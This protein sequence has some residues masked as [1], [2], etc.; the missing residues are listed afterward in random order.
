[1]SGS[2]QGEENVSDTDSKN[3]RVL[4]AQMRHI[5]EKV[6]NHAAL[7]TSLGVAAAKVRGG[8]TGFTESEKER[9]EEELGKAES[10]ARNLYDSALLSSEIEYAQRLL[11][12]AAAYV[13]EKKE[14]A[15]VAVKRGQKAPKVLHMYKIQ[16]PQIT[17][18]GVVDVKIR[19]YEDSDPKGKYQEW[20]N[21]EFEAT[22]S[23][24]DIHIHVHIHISIYLSIY[25]YMN[26]D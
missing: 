8:W 1:M 24:A 9:M 3:F 20:W 15:A 12:K 13:A 25:I 18:V 21:D 7:V 2:S 14:K 5:S 11:A 26:G 4:E 6:A 16:H 10:L 22:L 23:E 17:P 19:E